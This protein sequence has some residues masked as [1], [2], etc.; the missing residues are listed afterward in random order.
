MLCAQEKLDSLLQPPFCETV[1]VQ[2]QFID[3]L[4]DLNRL[5]HTGLKSH[6]GL[7]IRLG[8][9]EAVMSLGVTFSP[10]RLQCWGVLPV[11]CQ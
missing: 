5:K 6:L 7:V 11:D 8:A 3:A 2:Q 9:V 4:G 1:V 10:R